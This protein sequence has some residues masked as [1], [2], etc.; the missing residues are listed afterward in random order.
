MLHPLRQCSSSAEKNSSRC[1]TFSTMA[2][3]TIGFKEV[4]YGGGNFDDVCFQSK[5][6]GVEEL[7]LCSGYILP[8]SFR[9]CG[10]EERIV[11]APNR[12]HWWLRFTEVF[13][14]FR[15]KLYVRRVIQEQIELNLFVPRTLEQRR[16]QCVRLRRNTLWVRYA[17]G[18]LPARSA[19]RHNTLAEYVSIFCCG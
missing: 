10:N 3:D 1:R 9:S 8:K 14:K 7:N 16:I 2:P 17:V 15:I 6:P 11:L 19:H 12:K 4:H 13:L 18:V 5:M